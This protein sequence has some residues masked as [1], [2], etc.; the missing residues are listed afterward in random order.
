[1]ALHKSYAASRNLCETSS[2][3]LVA[4]DR[5]DETKSKSDLNPAEIKSI[6]T[7]HVV[8][9][10]TRLQR[11][12][13]SQI[14]QICLLLLYARQPMSHLLSSFTSYFSFQPIMALGLISEA[15]AD[16]LLTR[17]SLLQ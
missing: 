3:G 11:G 12:I 14:V 9:R 4:A 8:P 6:L 17:I 2:T 15:P 1:M 5:S 7:A 10:P 13:S 16:G